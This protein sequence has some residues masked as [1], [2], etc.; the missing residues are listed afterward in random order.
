[1]RVT[2]AVHANSVAQARR[3]AR[4][5]LDAEPNVVGR[6]IRARH[7][8]PDRATWWE[9]ELELQPKELTLWPAA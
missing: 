4:T 1:M 8:Y 9:V 3:E 5:W 2:I 6:V 7:P